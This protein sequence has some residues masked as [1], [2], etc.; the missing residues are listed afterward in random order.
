MFWLGSVGIPYL[1]L[2]ALAVIGGGRRD[3]T[4]ATEF[5]ELGM[6][7]CILGIG[8][9]GALFATAE[10]RSRLAQDAG[11]LAATFIFLTLLISGFCLRVRDSMS[12]SDVW[13]ARWSI[14]LGLFALA[15]NTAIVMK[16]G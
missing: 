6:D 15:V 10:I 11:I 14:F 9:S 5:S 3:A 8:V 4:V 12:L 13:K 2:V 16:F 7:A 1:A